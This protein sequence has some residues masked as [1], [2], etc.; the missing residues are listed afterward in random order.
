MY[1]ATVLDS[2]YLSSTAYAN[3]DPI[4]ANS[5][6]VL[7]ASNITS[8]N[9]TYP[10]VIITLAIGS[11]VVR[12]DVVPSA[13]LSN[14]TSILGVKSLGNINGYPVSWS[15][16]GQWAVEWTGQL[17]DGSFAPPGTYTLLVRALRVFGDADTP[18]DYQ[19]SQTVPFIISYV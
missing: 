11:A 3:Y 12:V 7:P 19:V 16:R 9:T 8:Y 14:V 5:S 17:E 2:A 10:G 6:F 4:D 15:S 13:P 18:S 1:N